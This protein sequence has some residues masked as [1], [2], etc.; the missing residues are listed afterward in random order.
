MDDAK[1]ISAGVQ[2]LIERLRDDGVQAGRQEAT[3]L[4]KEAKSQANAILEKATAESREIRDRTFKE[5][6][7][8]RTAA[9]EALQLAVRD[10]VLNLKSTIRAHF[11]AL[12]K[13]L[14]TLELEDKNFLQQLILAVAGQASPD[15]AG[16][17]A[18][19]I[20]L[21]NELFSTDTATKK[22]D[23]DTKERMHQCILAITGEMLR[24]GVELKPG[25]GA[26]IPG[27]RLRLVGEDL[28]IDLTDKAISDH[29]LKHLIPRFRD[30]VEGM[31]D[32]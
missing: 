22:T 10:T 5:I 17:T 12:V 28:E 3:N 8:E 7:A 19:E 11:S 13:R 18:M 31:T 32:R 14:V 21:P 30:I 26:N 24:N 1:H 23:K 25:G 16:D 29:L 20:L 15:K 2:E 27:I 6:D 4:I 9:H